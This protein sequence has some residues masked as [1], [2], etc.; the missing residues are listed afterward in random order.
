MI[1]RVSQF[2]LKLETIT[3]LIVEEQVCI[4][5]VLMSKNRNLRT[6]FTNYGEGWYNNANDCKQRRLFPICHQRVTIL[7]LFFFYLYY[8]S[9][10]ASQYKTPFQL[11][12]NISQQLSLRFY[13]PPRI[14][15]LLF[16][17]GS[18][19]PFENFFVA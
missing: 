7:I 2:L 12:F 18:G 17:P 3:H 11:K 4:A 5:L 8:K 13:L 14:R 9:S 10:Y 6:A 16:L 15:V 1:T 19:L